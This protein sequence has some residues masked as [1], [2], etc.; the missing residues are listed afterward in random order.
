MSEYIDKNK[1]ENFA[2]NC[3]GGEVSL[4]Q[5]HDFPAAD[6]VE[7][8]RGKWISGK[9]DQCGEHAPYWCMASTYCKSNFCP[10][11]GAYM[12]GDNDV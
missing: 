9:C 10:N 8:K 4:R 12:R 2:M 3:V 5:I 6:V 1:L 7:R 11:C